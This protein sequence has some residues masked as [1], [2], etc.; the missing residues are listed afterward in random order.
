MHRI[1]ATEVRR[2]ANTLTARWQRWEKDPQQAPALRTVLRETKD[3]LR[4]WDEA[5]GYPDHQVRLL[6]DQVRGIE[7][8]LEQRRQEHTRG[9]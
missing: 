3:Q 6:H 4:A 5:G 9:Y 1:D 2:Q 7:A 8:L